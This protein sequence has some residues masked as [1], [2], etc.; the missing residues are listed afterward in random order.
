[1]P[2][3][4]NRNPGVGEYDIEESNLKVE[5]TAPKYGIPKAERKNPFEVSKEKKSVPGTGAYNIS[6]GN[7]KNFYI[8]QK[9]ER[10]NTIETNKPGVGEYN[11]NDIEIKLKKKEPNIYLSKSERRDP[12]EVSK[13]KKKYSWDRLI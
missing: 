11:I 7:K 4:D 13:E 9:V 2:N 10:F 6:K 8:E 1:M 3:Y 12:F 5:K